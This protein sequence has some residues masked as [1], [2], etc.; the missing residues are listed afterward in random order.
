MLK[1]LEKLLTTIASFEWASAVS[2]SA[3]TGCRALHGEA[4]AQIF[5]CQHWLQSFTSIH[6]PWLGR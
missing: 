6:T 2:A 5:L 3:S 4:L 1:Y